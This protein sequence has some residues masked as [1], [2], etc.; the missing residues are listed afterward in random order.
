VIRLQ[1]MGAENTEPHV[2]ALVDRLRQES[3]ELAA[4]GRDI[5]RL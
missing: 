4:F 2:L 1:A 3:A 5:M